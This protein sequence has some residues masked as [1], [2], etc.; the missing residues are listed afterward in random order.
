VN[1]AV[2]AARKAFKD[3][4]WKD[5]GGTARGALMF[6]LAALVDRDA[7]ILATIETWDN[8][9]FTLPYLILTNAPMNS[10]Y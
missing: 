3:P 7:E 2:K 9:S 8:G 1:D 6:K 4:S 5:L 10:T